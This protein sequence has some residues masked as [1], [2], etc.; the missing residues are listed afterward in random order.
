GR[1]P[2][3]GERSGTHAGR[4]QTLDR[5]LALGQVFPGG[6]R[7]ARV[8]SRADEKQVEPSL[9]SFLRRLF[10]VFDSDVYPVIYSVIFCGG[11]CDLRG[12][13]SDS[14]ARRRVRGS[15]GGDGGRRTASWRVRRPGVG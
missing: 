2:P 6:A 9:D 15:G 10:H 8:V 12:D 13:V 7:T 5:A 1:D 14:G 11:R 4:L 3:A